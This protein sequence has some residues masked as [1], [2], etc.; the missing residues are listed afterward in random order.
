MNL[1]EEYVKNMGLN[2]CKSHL[3]VQIRKFN[4]DRSRRAAAVQPPLVMMVAAHDIETNQ[5][6]L[7]AETES[8][9]FKKWPRQGND[10]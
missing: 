3:V 4:V 8:I 9:I 5:P 7:K 10:Y 6:E 2:C 1:D